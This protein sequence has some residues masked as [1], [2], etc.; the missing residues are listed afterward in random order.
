MADTTPI[1]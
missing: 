1:K